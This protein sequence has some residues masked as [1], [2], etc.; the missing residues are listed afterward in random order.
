MVTKKPPYQRYIS[1][2]VVSFALPKQEANATSQKP[3][4][5]NIIQFIVIL[6]GCKDE[7]YKQPKN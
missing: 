2:P 6:F 1:V 4:M 7:E 3:A 5:I